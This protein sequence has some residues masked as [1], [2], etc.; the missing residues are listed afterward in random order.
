MCSHGDAAEDE[1]LGGAPAQRHAHLVVQLRLRVDVP[2][3]VCA[4]QEREPGV[5]HTHTRRTHRTHTPARQG[6]VATL[7]ENNRE[8]QGGRDRAWGARGW[9]EGGTR[10]GGATHWSLGRYCA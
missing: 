1:G 5:S 10:G 6:E 7:L 3:V 8:D 9:H 2:T 4:R